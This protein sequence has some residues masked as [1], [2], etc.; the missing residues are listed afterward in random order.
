MSPRPLA[1]APCARSYRSYNE[2]ELVDTIALLTERL[3][4]YRDRVAMCH[5]YPF[6]VDH[7]HRMARR[8]RAIDARLEGFGVGRKGYTLPMRR[9]GRMIGGPCPVRRYTTRPTGRPRSSS[10]RANRG[11]R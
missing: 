3:T 9:R 1:P 11:T 6:D 4:I 5:V 10:G 7:F 2:R 8:E